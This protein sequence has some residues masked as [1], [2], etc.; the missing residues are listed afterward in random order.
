[1]DDWIVVSKEEVSSIGVC[2]LIWQIA[3]IMIDWRLALL[4]RIWSFQRKYKT[5]I[6]YL[7]GFCS[8]VLRSFLQTKSP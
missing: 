5:K 8:W 6:N 4:W 3:L 7:V 2:M 1:M